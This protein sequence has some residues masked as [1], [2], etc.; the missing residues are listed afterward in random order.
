MPLQKK[1]RLAPLKVQFTITNPKALRFLR[2]KLGWS[3]T[4]ASEAIK[5]T[6]ETQFALAHDEVEKTFEAE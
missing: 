1:A 2:A 4:L 5:R 3:G 6:I